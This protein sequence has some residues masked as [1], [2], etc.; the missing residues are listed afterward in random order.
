MWVEGSVGL[1]KCRWLFQKCYKGLVFKGPHASSAL[2]S[3]L[4]AR[5]PPRAE[6]LLY[7]PIID[8]VSP[9]LQVIKK[10]FQKSGALSNIHPK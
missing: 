9:F 10:I 8:V 7:S 1:H 2:E 4:P 3:S 6:G 5:R